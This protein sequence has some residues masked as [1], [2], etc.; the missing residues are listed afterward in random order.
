MKKI[1]SILLFYLIIHGNS[2][3]AQSRF[4]LQ[5]GI[6]YIEH[7]STGIVLKLNENELVSF[8]Y[9][10]NFFIKTQEFSSY[11]LQ[12]EYLLHNYTFK[13]CIPNI[14]IK[15]GYAIYTNEFYKWKLIDLVP[16]IGST[17]LINNRIEL[18][19]DIGITIS[20]ELSMKRVSDGEIGW[21][22]HVLPEF[23]IAISYNLL[24]SK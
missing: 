1:F 17:Y 4:K 23:K 18:S 13:K 5:S 21:Y 10:S 16:F 14:G 6:S 12:Y 2:I 20:R 19:G 15:G 9:G 8:I 22:K 3:N 24:Q 11:M 7:I